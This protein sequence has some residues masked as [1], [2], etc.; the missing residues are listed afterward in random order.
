MNMLPSLNRWPAPEATSGAMLPCSTTALR[1]R[2]SSHLCAL[3]VAIALML[4]TADAAM[5]VADT[6][7]T[8][9]LKTDTSTV[10]TTLLV[11]FGRA[12]GETFVAKDTLI[13]VI[14]IWRPAR[15]DTN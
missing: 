2:T 6:C 3:A 10:D 13:Q 15:Q 12:Y 8:V 4:S 7:S 1:Q 14:T 9:A 5:S 11:Y